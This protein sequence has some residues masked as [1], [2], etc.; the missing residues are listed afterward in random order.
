[1]VWEQEDPWEQKFK[2]LY[3][4][5]QE[6]GDLKMPIDY[7]VNGVWLRRWLSEQVARMNGKSI[8]QNGNV[9]KLTPEQTAKLQS[10]G[11]LPT[12]DRYDLG[13]EQKYQEAKAFY[14]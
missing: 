9:K 6:H 4:Y 10:V 8:W 11:V 13:W 12:A 5:Y 3:E 2:L 7:V 14:E 1:M